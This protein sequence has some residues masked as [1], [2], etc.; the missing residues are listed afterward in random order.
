AAWLH[1]W[2]AQTALGQDQHPQA[3]LEELAW[4]RHFA[5]PTWSVY[6]LALYDTGLALY[7]EGRY[8]EAAAL[9]HR[10]VAGKP[11]LHGVDL[12]DAALLYRE[13]R[14]CYGYHASHAKAGIPEP[15]YLD[16][17]CGASGLAL[18][19]GRWGLPTSKAYVAKVCKVTGRG[20]SLAD[21]VAGAR[22]VGLHAYPLA[23]HTE[24]VLM[25]LPKPL[26]AFVEH[27]HFIG[28]VGADKRGVEYVCSDCGP[29][30][31]GKVHVSWKQWALLE[32]SAYLA[33]VRPGSAQEVGL[34]ALLEG[35][36][37]VASR[38]LGRVWQSS[39]PPPGGGGSGGA[40]PI[41]PN[42]TLRCGYSPASPQPPCDC[43][44]P[45]HPGSG[46]A[47][48]VGA[49]GRPPVQAMA[50]GGPSQNDPV[51]LATGEE[52]YGPEE[53]LRV[54]NPVGPSVVWAREYESLR[55]YDPTYEYD[56]FGYGWTQS[57]NLGVYDPSTRLNPQLVA[58]QSGQIGLSGSDA[59]ASGLQWDI[60]YQ[61][62]TVASSSSP[63][64]WSV[65]FGYG[66]A[67][68]GV[69]SSAA[70]GI[71]YE[72][73]TLQSPP[74]G[75]G[76]ATAFSGYF[77]VLVPGSIPQGMTVTQTLTGSDHPASGLQWDILLNGQTVAT[78]SAP[79]GWQVAFVNYATISLTVSPYAVVGGG[80]EV[81]TNIP[82]SG[83]SSA[84][85]S[86][87][88]THAQPSAGTKYLYFPNGSRIRLSAPSVPTASNPVVVCQVEA[89]HAYLVS[90][91]Y[92][93]NSPFGH[94][95]IEDGGR[96]QWVTTGPAAIGSGYGWYCTV[97]SQEID[98]SG[99][100]INFVYSGYG[101]SGFPLLSAIT[102]KNNQVLLSITRQNNGTGNIWY[103][104]D[105]YGRSVYYHE[106]YYAS[107]NV[108]AGNPQGWMELDHVSQIVSSGSGNPPDKEVY[109]YANFS[110]GE[111]SETVA[112][113][114]T[115]SVPSPT[116]SG[117][118]TATITY[119]SLGS[120]SSL[121]DA[122]GNTTTFSAVD[123]SHSK[124][125][126][127]N[128]SGTVVASYVAGFDN[129]MSQTSLT[130][131]S[132]VVVWN[133]VYADPND[134]LRPSEVQDGNGYATGGANGKGTWLYTWDVYG[135]CLSATNPYGTV[136]SYTYSYT[137]FGLGELVKIQEGNKGPITLSYAEPS[138]YI[139][140]ITTSAPGSVG[141]GSR[142]SYS[143]SYDALGNLVKE[144]GPGNNA[145]A[146]EVKTFN[147]TSD[148]TY[149]Y[150]QAEGLHEPLTVTDTLGHVTHFRYDARGNRIAEIDALG[151]ETDI[152]YNLADQLVQI[153]FPASG[154]T[155][156]GRA[157]L[158]NVY[159]Y[160]GGLKSAEQQYNES[161]VLVWQVSYSYGPE[162]EVRSRSGSTQPV[163]QSYDG[164]YRLVGVTDGNGHTTQF[165]Y[166]AS[167][168]L[169]K[170]VYPNANGPYDTVQLTSY[171][172][173]GNVLQ[174]IDGRGITTNYSY[175]DPE[176]HLTDV[177]YPAD[178]GRNVHLS[179]DGYGRLV[180]MTD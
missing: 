159:L 73:R 91:V 107:Q 84:F 30:P 117:M 28:V 25:A 13:C 124:V 18:C 46:Q 171:D 37:E 123:G 109:G 52:E 104:S 53:D 178:A 11:A 173:D 87:V 79:N 63:N 114:H 45:Q 72:L 58:G 34:L 142:V 80:Y 108:P 65:S 92:D 35:R 86:V 77:D 47:G 127:T 71:N 143:F 155:G 121:V 112:F 163:Q 105:R 93:T 100:A 164:A 175:T 54:Y 150:S 131:G 128:A 160:V 1:L 8:A 161:G 96:T 36:V 177:Q 145:T 116:G 153:L 62:K 133:A 170:V 44:T 162:G 51:D 12:R 152:S 90:W 22:R 129:H 179:W 180:G 85:F 154:M 102:D 139:T 136:T 172:A 82:A 21:L 4:V 120:V 111:G 81:R 146:T 134:P 101:P 29:W 43:N 24:Q 49:G 20:S 76:S 141:G 147:Y 39:P 61:G 32:P 99:N 74:Y 140:G 126:V 9:F 70:G 144:V 122:N 31:G 3:A 149:N 169:A 148:P 118:S 165:V 6:G 168:Y 40:N 69:P 75:G 5:Q 115:I 174:R 110:D 56:D 166:N 138:G 50:L 97:L 2:L 83:A 55:G 68:V 158:V 137:N 151:N 89:G 27:D 98:P 132:G 156:S 10:L 167:G 42:G 119:S 135:N 88:A 176:S 57:Y 33:V 67:S 48:P 7:E 38:Y 15:A 19:F 94:Y 17:W 78:S 64:G 106:S 66:M 60:V 125:V 16:P 14:A 103:V 59:P 113:L 23:V 157:S 130:N 95:V 26:I 41:N